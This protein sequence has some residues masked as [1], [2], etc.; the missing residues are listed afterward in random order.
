MRLDRP[1]TIPELEPAFR[2]Y[3]GEALRPFLDARRLTRE[4]VAECVELAVER[5]DAEGTRLAR[6][7]FRLSVAQRQALRRTLKG[8]A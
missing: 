7:L 1:A 3:S 6:M 5:R 8:G 4:R 2:A